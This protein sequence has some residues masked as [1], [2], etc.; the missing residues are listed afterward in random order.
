[1]PVN[2]TCV[3][4]SARTASSTIGLVPIFETGS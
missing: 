1:L 2:T 3:V 4:V